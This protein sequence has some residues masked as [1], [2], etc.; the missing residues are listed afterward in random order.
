MKNVAVIDDDNILR[1]YYVEAF[2]ALG[3]EAAA[4]DGPSCIDPFTLE[5]L[6]LLVIDLMMPKPKSWDNSPE[7]NELLTGLYFCKK[8][9]ESGFDVPI[10]L[11]TS[12]NI[13]ELIYRVSEDTKNLVN[14]IF[15]LKSDFEPTSF[16]QACDEILRTGT[17]AGMNAS[18]GRRLARSIIVQ[19]NV[20]G[21]GCDCRRFLS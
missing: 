17:T 13:K 14:V 1:G 21:F 4:F 5:A 15:V 8:L 20:A 19:P 7:N 3:Y 2:K 9:R 16:A 10:V 6:D 12:L 18:L 11:F